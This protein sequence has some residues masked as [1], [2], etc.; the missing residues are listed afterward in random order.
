[1]YF[2]SIEAHLLPYLRLF[3]ARKQLK[4]VPYKEF[5]NQ[6]APD[7]SIRACRFDTHDCRQYWKEVMTHDG[8]CLI[9]KEHILGRSLRHSFEGFSFHL[10]SWV[11][12]R[13]APTVTH[14]RCSSKVSLSSTTAKLGLPGGVTLWMVLRCTIQ[15][16]TKSTS[17]DDHH[18]KQQLKQSLWLSWSQ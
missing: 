10:Q 18:F 12:I 1:M 11:Q 2:S 5:L 16:R 4:K 14:F 9:L 7:F 15:S 3:Q 8:R 6:T 13:E 17:K